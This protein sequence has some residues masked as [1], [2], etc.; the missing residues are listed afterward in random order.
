[1]AKFQPYPRREYRSLFDAW[2]RRNVKL[3]AGITGGVAALLAIETAVILVVVPDTSFRTWLLG[4]T[5]ATIVAI[6]LYLVH[7]TFLIREREAIWQLRGAWGEEATRDELRRAKRKRVVWGWIDSIELQAGDLDHL[8]L[9]RKGGFVVIDS[10]W[11]SRGTD[12]VEMAA[13]ARRARLRAEGLTRTLLKSERGSHRAKGNTVLVTPLVV[14]WGPA[15]HRVPDRCHVEGVDFIGGRAL[16]SWLQAIP[17]D[18]VDKAAAKEALAL[19]KDFRGRAS[20]AKS[21]V[22]GSRRSAAQA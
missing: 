6:G 22:P 2:A 9:P 19:L 20:E 5:Q 18:E 3:L 10:K 11:R 15:Q 14:I 8:V 4:A 17:G 12:A 1:M 7:S 21:A 16:V 13:S